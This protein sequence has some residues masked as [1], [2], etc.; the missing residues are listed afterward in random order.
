MWKDRLFQMD[1]NGQT[2]NLQIG[3]G[4]IGYLV[5]EKLK[6]SGWEWWLWQ[7]LTQLGIN[8][9]LRIMACPNVTILSPSKKPFVCKFCFFNVQKWLES[10]TG[11]LLLSNLSS[12]IFL[13][14][15]EC[16]RKLSK[17]L[18]LLFWKRRS[19]TLSEQHNLTGIDKALC[20]VPPQG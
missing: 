7:S 15:W 3:M 9:E 4:S 2:S 13:K 12:Y 17:I 11:G 19:P 20:F 16:C 18:I 14:R 8:N 10:N 6:F 1:H 5:Q